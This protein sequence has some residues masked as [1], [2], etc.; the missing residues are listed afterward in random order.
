MPFLMLLGPSPLEMSYGLPVL[1]VGWHSALLL[2]QLQ[3]K[4]LRRNPSTVLSRLYAVPARLRERRQL[5]LWL[6]LVILAPYSER[7]PKL[8]WRRRVTVQLLCW[9]LALSLLITPRRHCA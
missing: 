8:D 3:P 6:L 1:F 2:P 7:Q 9:S 5:L 4:K